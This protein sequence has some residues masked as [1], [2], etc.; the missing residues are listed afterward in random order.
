MNMGD[1]LSI[2]SESRIFKLV[3]TTVRRGQGIKKKHRGDEPTQIIIHGNV[4]RTPCVAVLTK[5]FFFL[6]QNQRT[7]G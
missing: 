3:E 1:I 6:L 4:T 7:G 2:Q 5:I